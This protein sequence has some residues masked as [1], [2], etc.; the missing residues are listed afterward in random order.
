[1]NGEASL[2]GPLVQPLREACRRYGSV[3]L[4]GGFSTHSCAR[5]SVDKIGVVLLFDGVKAF[6]VTD[7]ALSLSLARIPSFSLRWSGKIAENNDAI[8]DY[9]NLGTSENELD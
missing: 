2:R 9:L 6:L 7:V 8:F 4:A 5:N 3:G 1:M